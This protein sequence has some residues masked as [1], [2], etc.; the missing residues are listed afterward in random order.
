MRPG[1]RGRYFL[2]VNDLRISRRPAIALLLALIWVA[3][4]ARPALAQTAQAGVASA[5]VC[6]QGRISRIDIDNGGVGPPGDS[7]SGVVGWGFRLVNHLHVRTARGFIRGELLFE[8][9]DCFDP[10]LVID[11][12]R[13]LDRYS[14]IADARVLAEDDSVGGKRVRVET[15]DQWST[16][17]DLGV[18]YD[19]GLNLESFRFTEQNFLGRGLFVEASRH[20]R[21][22]QSSRSFSLSV[23]SIFQRTSASFRISSS[24]DGTSFSEGIGHPFA[25]DGGRFS[26]R[27]SFYTAPSLFAY[28]TDGQES[29]SHVLVPTR[30][31]QLDLGAATR[32]GDPGSSVVLGASLTRESYVPEVAQVVYQ[33]RFE[34]RFAPPEPLPGS[35]A[36]QDGAVAAT[37]L[38]LHVGLRHYRYETMAGLDAVRDR[39]TVGHGFFVGATIGKG[40]PLFTPDGATAMDDLYGRAHASW[41]VSAGPLLFHGGLTA[42]SRHD[43]GEWKDL[44]AE[45]EFVAYVRGVPGQIFFLRASGAGGWRTELPYQL[46]LGGRE[47]VRSLGND[48]F[49]GGRQ[50][51]FVVEDRIAFPRM[52]QNAFDLGATLFADLGRVWP[53]DA[54]FGTDS[55]WRAAAGFGLRIAF[56]AGSRNIWRP[57][58][59]FPVGPGADGPPMFR[60]TFE[61]NRFRAGFVT[62]DAVR[63]HRL[64]GAESF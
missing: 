59:V 19:E 37:R 32:L 1:A 60:V 56:P 28:V 6:P 48:R 8:E 7:A 25:G 2:T 44:L 51:L 4:P 30:V 13:I 45:A 11:S 38:G 26:A 50:A 42:E 10:L 49:P 53:G 55:G 20:Q 16:K 29:Y 33:G 14:F 39:A 64:V 9:G 43:L 23:P 12:Q 52:P 54:P 24:P 18:T 57:D 27:E 31:E 58:I 40:V 36:R 15:R 34:E 5:E 41:G 3:W 62:P 35:V 47:G 63:S 46:T 61:L 21:L 17:G 22:E